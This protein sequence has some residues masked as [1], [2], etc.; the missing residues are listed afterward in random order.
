MSDSLADQ[1]Y[2][3]IRG[4]LTRGAWAPGT[5]LANRAL[6]D[7]IGV[8]FTPVREALQRLASEGL[9][10]Y[11]PGAGAFVRAPDRRELAELYELRLVVEPYAARLAALHATPHDLSDLAACCEGFAA[12]AAELALRAACEG[13]GAALDGA[14]LEHWFDLEERFHRCVFEAG[15]NRWLSKMGLDLSFVARA[16]Q[17]QRG[18]SGLVTA[19]VA[20]E[21]W[22]SHVEL[23][24]RLRARDEDGA[25]AWMARQ[26]ERGR[27][28]VL[29]YF[30]RH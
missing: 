27:E 2:G 28:T 18:A 22:R 5:R 11:H 29:A 17:P 10:D 1:A 25:A 3:H 19:A 20:S 6:A 12:S 7:E 23:V 4:R 26:I 24:E 14:A 9:V 8:S 13:E 15:R 30:D 21:T 16:F